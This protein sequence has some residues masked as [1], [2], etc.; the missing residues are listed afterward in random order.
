MNYRLVAL[1]LVVLCMTMATPALAQENPY[2][3]AGDVTELDIPV[4]LEDG[5]FKSAGSSGIEFRGAGY[6]HRIGRVSIA[7][8]PV[9]Q[10]HDGKIAVDGNLRR[11]STGGMVVEHEVYR[12]LVKERIILDAPASV[13]YSYDLAL[14]DWVT[15]ETDESRPVEIRDANNTVIV[16]YP[17]TKEVTNYANESTIDIGP[18]RWGNLVV[19]V[20][21]EDVVVMPKPFAV[22][23]AGKR[24]DMDFELDRK[25]KT[26]TVA[27]DLA[28]AKYP[29]TV[30]P[31][32]RVTNGGFETG[33][34]N[35]WSGLGSYGSYSVVSGG[36]HAGNYYLNV[37]GSGGYSGIRQTINYAGVSS[38][39]TAAQIPVRNTYDIPVS[40]VWKTIGN[41]LI[42]NQGQTIQDWTVRSAST[43]L[44]GNSTIDIWTYSSTHGH[45]DSV[46]AMGADPP[47]ADFTGTPL[48]GTRPLMVQFTDTSTG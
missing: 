38:V 5:G 39:S 32:E 40:N 12:D 25:A 11:Y 14:S 20:N 35:G 26:I 41:W 34:L 15:L 2:R 23:A 19:Y 37:Q 3:H 10:K 29:V 7:M 6:T 18:D 47:V 9:D 31:T 33:G 36:A 22:D 21:G 17:Y 24:F 30:D 42:N 8:N 13:R 48:S 43:T 4:P 45:I 28:G 16:T 27:G 1:V 44:T 46:T